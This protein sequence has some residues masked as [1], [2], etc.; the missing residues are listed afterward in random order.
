MAESDDFKLDVEQFT[1]DNGMTFLIVQRTT[2]PVFTGYIMVGVGSASEKIGNIGTAHL[3]EHMMF[4]GS[5][6]VGTTDYE[7]ELEYWAKE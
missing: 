3:L 1:L 4:K 6:L 2:A 7:A 5:R